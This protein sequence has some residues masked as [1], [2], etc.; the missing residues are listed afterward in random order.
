MIYVGPEIETSVGTLPNDAA[1]GNRAGLGA[2]ARLE[3]YSGSSHRAA[4]RRAEGDGILGRMVSG[5]KSPG[6]KPVAYALCRFESCP[7]HQQ[8][9]TTAP[10]SMRG[11]SDDLI[12]L[13][14]D[15][16]SQMVL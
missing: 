9:A 13:A 10:P 14:S 7:A 11:Q 5:M 16:T 15:G 1:Q 4:G 6:C 8:R 12:I 2:D 3:R